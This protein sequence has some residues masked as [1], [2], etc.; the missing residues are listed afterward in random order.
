MS[1]VADIC[2]EPAVNDRDIESGTTPHDA[3]QDESAVN[4]HGVKSTAAPDSFFCCR[5]CL[6]GTYDAT[7]GD[8]ASE[9][10]SGSFY[11]SCN[12]NHDGSGTFVKYEVGDRNSDPSDQY[13]GQWTV[14]ADCTVTLSASEEL[15]HFKVS[16]DNNLEV[17]P[18]T[19]EHFGCPPILQRTAVFAPKN[20]YPPHEYESYFS[21]NPARAVLSYQWIL[22]FRKIKAFLCASN[23]R[24]HNL[25]FNLT[26]SW[27]NFVYEGLFLWLFY[28]HP[29]SLGE[30]T[31]IWIDILFNNQLQK[32]NFPAIL[33]KADHEYSTRP[34]HIALS[35]DQL[36]SRVWIINEFA[37]RKQADK[38]TTLLTAGGSEG[39][40]INQ[41]RRG[42]KFM[43][44]SISQNIEQDYYESLQATVEEDKKQIREKLL[45]VY[46]TKDEFNQRI[47]Q[48]V[49]SLDYDIVEP[50]FVGLTSAMGI[51][52][53]Y[54][55]PIYL[56]NGSESS[57][58]A[59]NS[60]SP[61]ASFTNVSMIPSSDESISFGIQLFVMV[62]IVI[63]WVICI[64][65]LSIWSRMFAG[66]Y[67][68]YHRY[69]PFFRISFFSSTFHR[70]GTDFALLQVQDRGKSLRLKPHQKLAREVR[71][72]TRMRSLGRSI[73][74]SAAH[75]D[76]ALPA[77]K[78]ILAFRVT[79]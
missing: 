78:A 36:L 68:R 40:R 64:N 20:I 28:N 52:G 26:L 25:T 41:L 11:Y 75:C 72:A 54:I 22:D 38:Y 44:V 4:D 62:V 46:G 45:K 42:W 67:L 23:L 32:R 5:R 1:I 14:G 30:D 37:K 70:F 58:E 59:L 51:T 47:G 29:E 13:K 17:M 27:S 2:N 39:K 50:I 43:D 77:S 71:T 48:L 15:F 3:Q 79:A 12:F 10:T 35:T 21:E 69:S 56:Y 55:F 9:D 57:L 73:S 53:G 63:F 74:L 18:A 34:I 31:T 33:E 60:T 49:D 8:P 7:S 6:S 19:I 24:E 65:S 61:N 16:C 66:H 76:G